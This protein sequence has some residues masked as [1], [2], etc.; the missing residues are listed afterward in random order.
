M[1]CGQYRRVYFVTKYV[2][3]QDSII[4]VYFLKLTSFFYVLYCICFTASFLFVNPFEKDCYLLKLSLFLIWWNL[5][6]VEGFQTG[7]IWLR[8]TE[9]VAKMQDLNFSLQLFKKRFIYHLP[10]FFFCSNDIQ[11]PLIRRVCYELSST[12]HAK[13]K[14]SRKRII[15]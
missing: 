13:R 7:Y 9:P 14:A 3:L 11:M 6:L 4:G 10:H 1:S 2:H 8:N 12:L 5:F 15:C